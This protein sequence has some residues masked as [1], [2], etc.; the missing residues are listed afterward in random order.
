[1]SPGERWND[2]LISLRKWAVEK[3]RPHPVK[4]AAGVPRF[5]R[6]H[7]GPLQVP[8]DWWNRPEA[9]MPQCNLCHERPLP[10]SPPL[11]GGLCG[12]CRQRLDE[13]PEAA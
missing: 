6:R 7:S 9:V 5:E 13:T 11:V 2:K 4:P 3:M 12:P 10:G 8:S 1:M